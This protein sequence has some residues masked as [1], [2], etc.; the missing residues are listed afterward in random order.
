MIEW[1]LAI[2]VAAAVVVIVAEAA[3]IRSQQLDDQDACRKM[4]FDAAERLIADP[5]TPEK[6]ITEVDQL[7]HGM[8]S[9]TAMWRF[10]WRALTGRVTNSQ[11]ARQEYFSVPEHLRRELVTLWVSAIFA[12]TFNNMILGIF[13][14]R[15]VLFSVPQRTDGDFSSAT[16][17]TPMVDEF[18]RG[19]L[20]SA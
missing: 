3:R 18:A 19:K 7:A 5:E 4:F 20:R 17:V 15:L 16:P 12:A 11:Q 8:T 14:R 9:R 10:V 13:I 6:V 1:T 2:F